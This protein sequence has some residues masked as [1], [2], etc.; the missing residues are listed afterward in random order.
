[1]LDEGVVDRKWNM[2]LESN[3][4]IARAESTWTYQGWL[5]RRMFFSNKVQTQTDGDVQS[6]M[7]INGVSRGDDEIVR[8]MSTNPPSTYKGYR[9]LWL[10]RNLVG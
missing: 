1:M 6:T 10:H 5:L 7:V 3:G 4:W 9:G 8:C 2:E